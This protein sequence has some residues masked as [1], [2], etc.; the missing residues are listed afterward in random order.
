[1]SYRF[2][3]TDNEAEV[4]SYLQSQRIVDTGFPHSVLTDMTQCGDLPNLLLG[5]RA[6]TLLN[7][8]TRM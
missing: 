5:A 4:S 7:L 2:Y 8:K 3:K 6:N 1:M